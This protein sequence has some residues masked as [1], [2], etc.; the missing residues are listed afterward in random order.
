[1]TNL[2]HGDG[3][4]PASASS[5][6]LKLIEDQLAEERATKAA[7]EAR[8]NTVITSAGTLTTLLFALGA[9]ATKS[10]TYDLPDLAKGLLVMAVFCF[11]LAILF[12]LRA[13]APATY[14]ELSVKSLQ[15]VATVEAFNAP[16]TEAEPKI[17]AALVEVI[18]GARTGNKK[19]ADHL[20]RAVRVE[21]AAATV[22]AIAV[23]V[24]L[25]A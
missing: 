21:L 16:A 15:A 2:Q 5:A 20:N 24:V 18:D 22:L 8:A 14:S 23:I 17:A 10:N 9:L 19:K 6:A 11:L 1:M 7:L 4:K 25:V 12:A 13:A 3:D